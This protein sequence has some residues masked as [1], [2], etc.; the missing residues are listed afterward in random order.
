M[1]TYRVWLNDGRYH[2]ISADSRDDALKTLSR[3][4]RKKVT[5]V[6]AVITPAERDYFSLAQQIARE[7]A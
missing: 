5:K 6:T 7:N 2:L 4:K 1:K 3:G